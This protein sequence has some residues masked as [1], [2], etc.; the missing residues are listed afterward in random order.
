MDPQPQPSRPTRRAALATS[1]DLRGALRRWLARRERARLD[2]PRARRA[3]ARELRQAANPTNPPSHLRL[4]RP[5]LRY[6]AAAVRLELLEIA[7]LL[8][9]AQ[10]PNPGP[11]RAVRELLRDRTSPLYDLAVDVGEL[12]TTLENL[13]Q[14]LGQPQPMTKPRPRDPS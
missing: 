8:E 11:V 10:N 13:R 5:V 14:A 3:L 4:R 1:I 9:H 12:R 7:A 6:R 2:K